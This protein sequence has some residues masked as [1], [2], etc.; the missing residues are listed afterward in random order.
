M[1]SVTCVLCGGEVDDADTV[2]MPNGLYCV[3]C[4]KWLESLIEEGVENDEIEIEYVEVE[5]DD[6]D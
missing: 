3:P 5:E 6:E 2:E 4:Y 1:R